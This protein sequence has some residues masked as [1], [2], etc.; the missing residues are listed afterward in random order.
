VIIYHS[1]VRERLLSIFINIGSVETTNVLEYI[2]ARTTVRT[3]VHSHRLSTSVCT[4]VCRPYCLN[5]LEIHV[6]VYSTELITFR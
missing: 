5:W 3:V 1:L 2:L 4:H 6:H